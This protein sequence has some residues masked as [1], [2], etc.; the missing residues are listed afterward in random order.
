[1]G[2]KNVYMR[3]NTPILRTLRAFAG[4][5]QS[6]TGHSLSDAESLR[7]FIRLKD[8]VLYEKLLEYEAEDRDGETRGESE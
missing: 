8:S 2:E 5:L 6:Q 7:E 1:M 4:Q 3:V